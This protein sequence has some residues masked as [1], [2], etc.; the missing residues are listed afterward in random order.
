MH[1]RSLAKDAAAVTE[2][3]G[4]AEKLL[5]R[6]ISDSE[7]YH[8]HK[9]TM[10]HA[11]FLVM[12]GLFGGALTL[13]ELPDWVNA[14]STKVGLSCQDTALVLLCPLWFLLNAFIRWQL[15]MRRAAALT[16]AGAI[17]A[18]SEWVT[19]RP[20]E[21]DLAVYLAERTIEDRKRWWLCHL[22]SRCMVPIRRLATAAATAADF[23]IPFP[24]GTLRSDVGNE[25]YPHWLA[26]AMHRQAS[27]KGT[28]AVKAEVL[29]AFGSFLVLGLVVIRILNTSC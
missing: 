10:A 22:W 26:S 8:A 4:R 23:V 12:L 27:N 19:R 1:T 11:G 25:N 28:G 24:W 20:R 5:D 9:E 17:R 21:G 14:F 13:E 18:L 2:R 7:I 29:V 15:R 6:L 16:Q 3:M